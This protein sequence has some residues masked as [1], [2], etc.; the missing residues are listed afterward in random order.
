MPKL[1]KCIYREKVTEMIGQRRDGFHYGY[2]DVIYCNRI[3]KRYYKCTGWNCGEY[4][5]KDNV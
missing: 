5:V 3:N 4:K 1:N 2:H